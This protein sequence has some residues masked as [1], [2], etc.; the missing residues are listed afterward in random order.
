[1]LGD[2]TDGERDFDG[3]SF[4][5]AQGEMVTITVDIAAGETASGNAGVFLIGIEDGSI[6]AQDRS[7][8]PNGFAV[9]LPLTGSFRLLVAEPSTGIG[10]RSF[11]GGYCVTVDGDQGAGSTL[12]AGPTVEQQPMST[13]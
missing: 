1:V 6:Y 3:F 11:A 5:G 12:T 8:M 2:Q 10:G 7:D 13:N 4:S 9:S